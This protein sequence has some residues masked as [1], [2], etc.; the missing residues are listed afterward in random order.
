VHHEAPQSATEGDAGPATGPDRRRVMMLGAAAGLGVTGAA[1]LA[2]C[3]SGSA[4]TTTG[5]DSSAG[6][7]A[8]PTGPLAKLTDIP[9]GGSYASSGVK[10]QP[11]VIAQP[12]AGKVVAFSASCTHAGCKVKPEG[13]TLTC[14]C[15]NTTFDAFTGQVLSGPAST[16]LPAVGVKLDG[17]DVVLG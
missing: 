6:A 17:A 2:G 5:A 13:K 16:P 8:T 10:G 12:E 9:V 14:P 11:I 15:H 3:G 1:A 4:S 7:S